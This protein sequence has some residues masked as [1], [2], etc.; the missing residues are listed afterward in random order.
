VSL[1]T[2]WDR[3]RGRHLGRPAYFRLTPALYTLYRAFEREG[4]PHVRGAVLD[5]G[6]GSGAWTPVLARVGAERIVAVDRGAAP[7]LDAIADLKHL[8]YGDAS[9][10]TVFCSQVLEHDA[11]PAALLTE[12]RRVLKPGGVLL[13]SVPHLSRI[14][15]APH[16]YFRFTTYGLRELLTAA[17]FD[18]ETIVPAGGLLVFLKHNLNVVLLAAFESLPVVRTFAAAFARLTTPLWAALDRALDPGILFPMNYLA[19]ARKHG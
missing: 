11:A 14:H 17:G 7:G 16:D 5:A 1:A 13:I 15:D 2:N 3:V 8:P 18:V 4:A 12:L 19:R 9:F 10:E 6:A